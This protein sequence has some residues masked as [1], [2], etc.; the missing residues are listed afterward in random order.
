MAKDK[1]KRMQKQYDAA[2]AEIYKRVGEKKP[3]T[4]LNA[5]YGKAEN[6][7]TIPIKDGL[8]DP[9]LRATQLILWV[10]S[11]EPS[12]YADM[13]RAA[14]EGT[15]TQLENLGPLA[16]AMHWITKLAETNKSMKVTLG[17]KLHKPE[18]GLTHELGAWCSSDLIFR[19]TQMKSEWIED[20]KSSVGIKGLKNYASNTITE[21]DEEKP[22]YICMQGITSTTESFRV[23]LKQALPLDDSM[24]TVMFIISLQNYSN[25]A[26]FRCDNENYTAHVSDKEYL[27]KDGI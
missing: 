3:N 10:Y 6:D 17:A 27:L 18:K 14:R 15:A 1:V 23:A 20:W 25:V 21:G 22:A 16:Y 9:D 4:P 12:F 19:G 26:G 24:E 5:L 7:R 11:M 8:F 2:F 13:L